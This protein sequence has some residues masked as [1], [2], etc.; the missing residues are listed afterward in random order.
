MNALAQDSAKAAAR[1]L[2]EVMQTPSFAS[3]TTATA[4]AYLQ[5]AQ[6]VQRESVLDALANAAQRPGVAR[7]RAAPGAGGSSLGISPGR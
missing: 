7:L 4:A 5:T 2:A 3:E 1:L 6:I